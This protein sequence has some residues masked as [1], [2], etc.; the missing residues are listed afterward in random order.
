MAERAIQRNNQSPMGYG[1]PG[2]GRTPRPE[3][4]QMLLRPEDQQMFG[5]G[6]PPNVYP[7]QPQWRE[8]DIAR[9]EQGR[10]PQP[11][12]LPDRQPMDHWSPYSTQYPGVPGGQS[13]GQYQLALSRNG[14]VNPG[15]VL[16]LDPRTGQY[17]V[18]PQGGVDQMPPGQMPQGLATR[19][20]GHTGAKATFNNQP[21]GLPKGGYNFGG[22]ST[23]YQSPDMNQPQG[24]DYSALQQAVAQ[25]MQNGYTDISGMRDVFKPGQFMGQLSGFNTG[26]WGSG[27][28]GSDTLKNMM[29]T[30]FSNHD[31][32]Q[33]G[34]L[35][36]A[37]PD[38]QKALPQATIVQ[39]QNEDLL[40]PDG[41]DGPM[42]PVDVIQSAVA[43]GS[44]QAWAWQPTDA[45]GGGMTSG[46]QGPAAQAYMS[47]MPQMTNQQY[48]QP[49]M[50][51]GAPQV[52]DQNSAMQFLQWLMQQQQQ[53]QMPQYSTQRGF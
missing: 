48:G 3:L 50:L 11:Q 26:A 1:Q 30:I 44:G 25:S 51:D 43:G 8:R 46:P 38:I 20:W 13:G 5:Q 31:V 37:L 52:G 12:V 33:Q 9:E 35:R 2:R 23:G 4:A 53:G 14:G 24:Q 32:S 22:D 49:Q 40:D 18:F 28:R 27:E 16:R 42:A 15:G 29:G 34:A 17:D 10:G 7:D 36:N 21:Q 41:P 19:S 39:Q 47:G 6:Q 45:G